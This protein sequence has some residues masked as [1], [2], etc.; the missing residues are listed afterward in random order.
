MLTVDGACDESTL[1]TFTWVAGNEL[2]RSQQRYSLIRDLILS[3]TN[4]TPFNNS[5]T[6]R[7]LYVLIAS[8]E[9]SESQHFE[10]E[11]TV[12]LLNLSATS[13]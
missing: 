7:Q 1:D 5:A 2:T 13:A 12:C 11:I 10:R 8:E 3:D 9:G 4:C 6:Q